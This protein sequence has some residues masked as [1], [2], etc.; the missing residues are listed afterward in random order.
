MKKFISLVLVLIMCLS[1]VAC[2]REASK[3]N[4]SQAN[5]SAT[6][7]KRETTEEGYGIISRKEFASCVT[8]IELTAENWKEYLE[9]AEITDAERNAFG[10]VTESKT[11][12]ECIV[13]NALG[14]N[15][16]DVAMYLNV[17]STGESLYCEDM[18]YQLWGSNY[19]LDWSKYEID[20]L[21]CEK[22]TGSVLVLNNVPEECISFYEDGGKFL[23]LGSA[24]DY[25][26]IPLDDYT[27]LA[28]NISLAYAMYK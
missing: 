24:D 17:I 2:G 26:V 7:Q 23:C 8:K 13:K 19:R 25:M 28:V 4:G 14:W 6:Q 5:N 12:T 22:I 10:E 9:I 16:T 20:D 21:T 1:L 3:A 11:S 27:V 15:F 18:S